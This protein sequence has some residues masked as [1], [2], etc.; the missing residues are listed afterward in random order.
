MCLF[1]EIL[2]QKIT[3]SKLA[4]EAQGCDVKTFQIKTL[5]RDQWRHSGAFIVKCESV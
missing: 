3:C 4:F 2:Q 5:E 1:H